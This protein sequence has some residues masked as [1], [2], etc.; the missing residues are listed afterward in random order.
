MAREAA[1]DIRGEGGPAAAAAAAVASH[2]LL[3]LM[4]LA[5]EAANRVQAVLTV[6]MLLCTM[7]VMTVAV[8]LRRRVR[9]ELHAELDNIAV[10][11]RSHH[12]SS[13]LSDDL[14]V[15]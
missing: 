3:A 2:G 12:P 1:L 14:N 5:P 11:S 15:V 8:S 6:K 9:E 4:Y 13:P 10:P 7:L